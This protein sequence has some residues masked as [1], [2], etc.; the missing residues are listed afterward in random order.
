MMTKLLDLEKGCLNLVCQQIVKD[1]VSQVFFHDGNDTELNQVSKAN[2]DVPESDP[3]DDCIRQLQLSYINKIYG[4]KILRILLSV[5]KLQRSI[6]SKAGAFSNNSLP[7][8][9]SPTIKLD[10]FLSDLEHHIFVTQAHV[11]Q[12]DL[13][14]PVLLSDIVG[15][16]TVLELL[17]ESNLNSGILKNGRTMRHLFSKGKPTDTQIV[18]EMPAKCFNER[19]I[20][21]LSGSN[22]ADIIF[23]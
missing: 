2:A 19:E 12:A 9:Q 10:T 5:K 4:S 8:E 23:S 6:Q 7:K 17:S 1:S 3:Y 18:S 22:D 16:Q 14:P 11:S 21:W 20:G 15:E 13:E